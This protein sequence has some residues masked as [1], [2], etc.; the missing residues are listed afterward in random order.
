MTVHILACMHTCTHIPTHV[1]AMHARM[2]AHVRSHAHACMHACTESC[3]EEKPDLE[4][5]MFYQNH[6]LKCWYDQW[7][8]SYVHVNTLLHSTKTY[9][10]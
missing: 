5:N 1:N 8:I 6:A 4:K 2:H 10:I 3:L 7:L 9:S